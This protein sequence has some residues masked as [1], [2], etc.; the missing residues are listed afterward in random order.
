MDDQLAAMKQGAR[1]TWAAGDFDA[2]ATY[3]KEVGEKVVAAAGVSAGESVLDVACGTGNAA[4]PAARAGARLVGLDLTPELLDDAR[5]NLAAEGL[6][7]EFIEGDAEDLPFSDAEFDVVLSTFGCMFAPRH[8]VAAAEIARVLKPGG[9]IA[10]ASWTPDGEIGEFFRMTASHLPAPPA[11]GTGP[12]LMWGDPDHVAGLFAGSGVEPECRVETVRM[13][14]AS[15]DDAVEFYTTKF[16][17]L[18]MA[19][20]ALE[21]AGKWDGF[22]DDLRALYER[23]NGADDGSLALAPDYLLVSGTKSG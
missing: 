1:A 18:V 17:P 22:V 14:F 20:A 6:D 11:G 23:Q 9:R 21:P 8:D 16:G 4:I 10:I 19:R 2:V 5:R 15:I 13:N 3:I 7:G 12:P